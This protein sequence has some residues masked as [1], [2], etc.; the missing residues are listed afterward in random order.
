M[1]LILDILIGFIGAI[2]GAFAY[3]QFDKIKRKEKY[4]EY[5][6]KKR[7]EVY[8]DIMEKYSKM[9][10][11]LSRIEDK[12]LL[13]K[14]IKY[15]YNYFEVIQFSKRPFISAEMDFIISNLCDSLCIREDELTPIDNINNFEGL[16]DIEN[17]SNELVNQVD[18]EISS[19]KILDDKDFKA[20]LKGKTIDER[21]ERIIKE[22]ER[23]ERIIKNKII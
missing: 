6:F 7:V 17:C 5:L 3:Y 11:E 23:R 16:A 8:S 15:Y 10:L 22:D 4:R 13:N 1:Q 19:S 2:F 9:D 20:I 18:K 21:R 12:E 14:K